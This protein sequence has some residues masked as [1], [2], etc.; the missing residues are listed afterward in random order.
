MSGQL[1]GPV[2]VSSGQ[3]TGTNWTGGCVDP[4]AGLDVLEKIKI[5]YSAAIRILDRPDRAHSS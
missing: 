3:N 1:D 5:S 4:R 2:A